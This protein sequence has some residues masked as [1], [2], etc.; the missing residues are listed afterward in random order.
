MET[1][2]RADDIENT[3]DSGSIETLASDTSGNLEVNGAAVTENAAQPADVYAT[4]EKVLLDPEGG[5]IVY[6]RP[7]EAHKLNAEGK[8]EKFELSGEARPFAVENGWK[9]FDAEGSETDDAQLAQRVIMPYPLD[10][11]TAMFDVKWNECSGPISGNYAGIRCNRN[12]GL[13]DEY[14]AFLKPN[15]L[16]C[17]NAGLAAIGAGPASSVH[18]THDGTTADARHSGGSLHSAGRAID[19]KILSTVEA[20]RKSHSFD[21]TKTNTD[22]RLSNRCAP[23]GT[24]NCKFFERFRAC[25]HKI[26]VAR[27]CPARHS[28]PIGTIGWEDRKHIAHHL[29][30][31]MPFCPNNRGYFITQDKAK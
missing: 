30:T 12:R 20:D 5:T 26:H 4:V 11:S 31:S 8:M 13:S 28:G 24:P 25:W 1:G 3:A 10:V 18:I 19:V 9:L 14:M 7:Y 23:A 6:L 17:V 2:A 16:G 22:R 27:R 29:H 15:F 21:F